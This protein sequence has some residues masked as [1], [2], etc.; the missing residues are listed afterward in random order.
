MKFPAEANNK[1]SVV[2]IQNGPQLFEILLKFILITDQD[3]DL[4]FEGNLV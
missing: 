2:Q 4:F 3:Y 1:I